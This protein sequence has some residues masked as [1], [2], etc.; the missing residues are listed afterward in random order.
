MAAGSPSVCVPGSCRSRAH[1]HVPGQ[2]KW[3]CWRC[4]G[5]LGLLLARPGACPSVREPGPWGSGVTWDAVLQSLPLGRAHA[6]QTPPPPGPRP[7]GRPRPLVSACT[8]RCSGATVLARSGPRW[9]GLPLSQ[10]FSLGGRPLGPK[11]AAERWRWWFLGQPGPKPC[12]WIQQRSAL[13]PLASFLRPGSAPH[14]L[15]VTRFTHRRPEAL[16]HWALQEWA[17]SLGIVV[18]PKSLQLE[19]VEGESRDATPAG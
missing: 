1:G 11:R 7:A 12:P 13:F 5:S 4:P 19:A 15:D 9:H 8:H 10:C 14:Y 18:S 6:T 3:D 17:A 16:A 2:L